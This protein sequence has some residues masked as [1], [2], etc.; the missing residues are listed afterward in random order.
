MK[1]YVNNG[2]SLKS[3][4]KECAAIG[5]LKSIES[6]SRKLPG[7]SDHDCLGLN[8]QPA[9]SHANQGALDC[10]AIEICTNKLPDGLGPASLK[11]IKANRTTQIDTENFSISFDLT[12]SSDRDFGKHFLLAKDFS[13]L[14]RRRSS[15]TNFFDKLRANFKIHSSKFFAHQSF[16]G[17]SYF[18]ATIRA[19]RDEKAQLSS[20][21]TVIMSI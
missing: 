10:H 2:I 6:C 20:L 12:P 1:N 16:F 9:E 8:T 11:G 7:S 13:R 19:L 5:I 15:K 17:V 21:R 18:L 4:D 14:T 3:A